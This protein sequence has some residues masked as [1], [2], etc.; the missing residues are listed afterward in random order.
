MSSVFDL[1]LGPIDAP[2]ALHG[3]HDGRVAAWDQHVI[4]D[5]VHDG[6][7]LP[8]ELGAFFDDD[9]SVRSVVRD[10]HVRE[11]DWG[12][13]A[14]AERLWSPSEQ[15]VDFNYQDSITPRSSP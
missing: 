7:R 9:G 5:V 15:C 13:S 10:A 6:T 4:V 3:A 12:A 11:R 2:Y 8:T 14:V 1:D